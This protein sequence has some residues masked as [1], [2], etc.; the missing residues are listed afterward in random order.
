MPSTERYQQFLITLTSKMNESTNK[1]PGQG[2]ESS[3]SRRR[4]PSRQPPS[5]VSLPPLMPKASPSRQPPS[6]V[7]LPPLMPKASS[8]GL[9]IPSVNSLSAIPTRTLL[10][11]K[12]ARALVPCPLGSPSDR[13]ILTP[14]APRRCRRSTAKATESSRVEPVDNSL[15]VNPIALVEDFRLRHDAIMKFPPEVND[16]TTR[17]AIRRFQAHTDN[18][19]KHLNHVCYCCSSFVDP[20][21][22]KHISDNDPIVMAAFDTDILH[23]HDLDHCGRLSN[24]F[25]FCHDCW[26]HVS[27]GEPPKFG[28][29]NKMPQLYC[30]HYP[31]PLEDLT[32]AEE[33]VIA[34]AHPVVTILKLRPN[35]SFNPGAYTGVRGHSVLLPQNPGPMLNLLPSETTSVD[36]VVQVVWAGKTSP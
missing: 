25:K 33:A 26:N 29:S 32:S 14:K 12:Q 19:I 7:S 3:P 22:L 20:A 30:Q 11:P 1:R 6:N 5:H 18:A 4:R 36:D 13:L 17:E 35:N 27:K 15:R 21:Q 9:S 24:S 8:P 2:L 34:R 16:S 10:A 23:C 31:K 28:V